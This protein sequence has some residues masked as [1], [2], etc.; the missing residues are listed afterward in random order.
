MHRSLGLLVASIVV[1]SAIVLSASAFAADAL[2]EGDR[3]LM[4][5]PSSGRFRSFTFRDAG[6]RQIPPVLSSDPRLVG[7]T[8]RVRGTAPGDGSSGTIVLPPGSGW[9]GLGVPA[10]SRGYRYFDGARTTGVKLVQIA[11][12]PTGGGKLSISAGGQNWPYV[13]G[14]PQGP[15]SVVVEVGGDRLCALFSSFEQNFAGKVTAQHAAAPAACDPGPSVACGN[16]VVDPGEECDDGNSTSGD[17]C[18]S[19]CT[20]EDAS[21]LCAGIATGSGGTLR[22]RRVASGLSSPTAIAAPRLDTRRVFVVEEPGRIR[23]IEDGQLLPTPFLSLGNKVFFAGERGLLGLAFH[24]DYQN[25]GLFFVNY[26]AS[27]NGDITIARYQVSAD[28]DVAD[29]TSGRV[30]VT[31]PHPGPS[32][33][34]GQLAFGGDGYLYVSTGDGGSS[35]DSL[36]LAQSDTVALGKMLRLD[37]DV[38]APPFVGIPASN[39]NPGAGIPL[40]L[41][42]A[43]GF[44]NPWRFSFDRATGDLYIGDV[45]QSSWEEIDFQAAGSPGGKNYGWRR[46]EGRHCFNP[47]TGCD[48]GTLTLPVLEYDHGQGCAVIGGFVYRGCRMP[49]L[50]G[51]Y[52]YSDFCSSFLRSFTG[53]SGGD[54]QNLADRSAEIEPPGPPQLQGVTTLGEDARGELYIADHVGQLFVIEPAS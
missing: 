33:Q 42:W 36:N 52:F 28:P 37:V 44:R 40:G 16:G 30:L 27:G 26:T 11:T 34:G 46:M 43:K 2:I 38:A 35:G 17:G 15:V 8:L 13:I 10:G 22:S 7:A 51:T 53:I 23:V 21:A 29:A 45:G 41:I 14:Q 25:N 20:L 50:R 54:A 47:P 39:P 24:P 5:D 4:A 3:L 19:T 32:H 6:D 18:S 12:S 48:D 9:K 1:L 31:I 49:D